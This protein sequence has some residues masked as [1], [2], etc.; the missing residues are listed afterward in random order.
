MNKVA[1]P[2]ES[3][4]SKTP[5]EAVKPKPLLALLPLIL[6]VALVAIFLKVGPAGVF[7]G[8]FPPVEEL[9]FGR[10]TLD[11]GHIKLVVT[12]GGP[13]PVQIS[14]VLVDDALWEFETSS[15]A[16]IPRLGSRILTIKY[17]W[18]AGE[19]VVIGLISTSG[20]TFEHEIGVAAATPKVDFGFLWAFALLGIYIGLVPV[21]LG[22]TWMPFLRT[23]SAGWLN[24]FMAFT[25]GVLVFLGVETLVEAIEKA[26]EL[27][28]ALGGIGVVTFGAVGAFALI[29]AA[30][31]KLQA[32]TGVNPRMVTAVTV[33]AGIGIHNLGEG[34]AVGAAYR[35]GEIALGAF[36]V[37]GFAVHNTTE[38]MGIVSILGRAKT[39]IM[40]LLGLGLLAGLPTV[41]GAWIGAFFYSPVLATAF[42]AIAAGAIA[43]VVVDVLGIVR[44]QSPGGLS[45]PP[46]LAG[47]ATGVVL[48]Y[49]T[50]ILVAA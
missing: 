44:K 49:L 15:S 33:A 30:S 19:P 14:Q 41:A 22:M 24:F 21:L 35:L 2:V 23:L 12:N 45:A 16:P 34:L 29:F 4:E 1:P 37:I 50:G 9:S 26:A 5:P 38:G 43:E 48:M 31:R 18:V 10:V 13:S 47:L 32:R 17:P 46:V 11:P 36:L 20:T 40:S 42:L 28:A 7:P 39:P 6:L 25:A 27:P 3:G 8:D